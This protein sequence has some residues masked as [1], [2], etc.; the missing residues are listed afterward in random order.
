MA[1][2]KCYGCDAAVSDDSEKCPKCGLEKSYDH[3]VHQEEDAQVEKIIAEAP[4]ALYPS[5]DAFWD[6]MSP[7]PE[8]GKSL[9]R[10]QH[11][12]RKTGKGLACPGC[13]KRLQPLSQPRCGVGKCSN[14]MAQLSPVPGGMVPSCQFCETLM[15]GECQSYSPR[16]FLHCPVA[17][18]MHARWFH[19]DRLLCKAFQRRARKTQSPTYRT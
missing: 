10:R 2:K 16:D 19:F 1:I 18:K 11:S 3:V 7:C 4:K 12:D 13:G 9:H 5:V 17:A 15:C 8:C 14:A 6:E